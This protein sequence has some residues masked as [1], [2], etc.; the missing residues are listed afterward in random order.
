[1]T[2]APT[3]S[4]PGGGR[5]GPS[6]AAS[7]GRFHRDDRGVADA[8]PLP[9]PARA[10][11]GVPARARACARPSSSRSCA[12]GPGRCGV[13]L[14]GLL[15]IGFAEA[16]EHGLR[17]GDL[18]SD[19]LRACHRLA[20]RLRAAGVAGR[21]RAERR[22]AGDGQRRAVRRARGGAVPRR[23]AQR[24]STSRPRSPRTAAGPPLGVLER[25]RRRG[26]PH[27]ALEAWRAGEPFRFR[28]AELGAI[29]V[30]RLYARLTARHRGRGLSAASHAIP[31]RACSS[32]I[33]V[34]L[35]LADASIV[36]LALPPML[37]E[38]DTTVEGVAAVIGVYTLVLALA[39]AAR[40][41]WLRRAVSRPALGAVGFARLRGRGRAVRAPRTR[42]A[43][44]SSFRALQAAGA[45]A[46]L[47]AGFALLRR[48]PAVDRRGR[49]RHRGR[50]GARRR[51]DPG[52]RLARDL[53]LPGP[54][55]PSRRRAAAW[56]RRARRG[57]AAARAA[58]RPRRA[59]RTWR[60]RPPPPRSRRDGARDAADAAVAGRRAWSRSPPSRPRSPAC[61][62][63][64]S[65]CSSP[66]GRSSRSPPRRGLGAPLAALAGA[67][68]RGA[69]ATRAG[70]GCA[71]VGGGVLALAVLPEATVAWIV[72]PAGARRR[73]HG[74]GAARARRRAAARS[75]RR[76]G[77]AA[78]LVPPRRHHDRAASSLAP[79]AAAPAR[80]RRDRR[81]AS[82]ARRWCSTRG[83]RR[84][85]RSSWPA[86]SSPTSIRPT[87]ATGCAA[88]STRQA[89]P[90]RRRPRGQRRSTRS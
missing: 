11:G 47:V 43:R 15:R 69:A 6:R 79:I 51:A 42:S 50:P 31:V 1:M 71:L 77:R 85:R 63:C 56:A 13:D 53:R 82:A 67:R 5:C 76:R 21:D 35:A 27:A 32:P 52:V 89:R 30:S 48:R 37:I 84:S 55:R 18:V 10:V 2:V 17:P 34:A 23:A 3:G 46:A 64:S 57:A 25:V 60:Q 19:D 45:A 26:A 20:D 87:R 7:P 62:S 66:A 38:L 70:A 8:V 59:R 81:R 24:A 78:A 29:R 75:A 40:G 90:L 33:G 49:L 65:C 9:A 16:A 54:A 73:R 12:T 39:P 88:R 86:R 61:S 72:A 4:R 14:D 28:R 22:A 68:I 36:T 58:R 41:A 44:C 80:R 74:P 83:S